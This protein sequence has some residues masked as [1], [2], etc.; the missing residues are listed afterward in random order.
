MQE[1]I[2]EITELFEALAV[3]GDLCQMNTGLCI[4]W[5]A[6]RTTSWWLL[7]MRTLRMCQLSQKYCCM[8]R[9]RKNRR[10]PR[11]KDR[12]CSHFEKGEPLSLQGTQRSS[13]WCANT[14]RS[15]ATLEEIA[16]SSRQ[17]NARGAMIQ[18]TK[19]STQRGPLEQ[20]S[21]SASDD[22]AM[23]VGHALSITSREICIVDF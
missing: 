21:N 6:Y 18:Q 12:F 14:E 16:G 8:R 20:V 2:E 23:V 7:W 19:Q 13:N 10:I 4:W 11:W 3:I 15:L 22:E 17:P 5:L 1:H 9:G